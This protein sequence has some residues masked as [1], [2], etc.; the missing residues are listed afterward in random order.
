MFVLLFSFKY[1]ERAIVQE[2]ISETVRIAGSLVALT[3]LANF[4]G[5]IIDTTMIL[6]DVA[7]F[8]CTYIW[9]YRCINIS[10]KTNEE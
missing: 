8:Y 2:M 9:F 7:R 5:F 3:S 1:R 6:P 10:S 4:F